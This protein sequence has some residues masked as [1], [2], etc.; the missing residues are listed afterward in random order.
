MPMTTLFFGYF[1][2]PWLFFLQPERFEVIKSMLTKPRLIYQ[3]KPVSPPPPVSFGNSSYKIESKNWMINLFLT[4]LLTQRMIFVQGRELRPALR[5]WW[6][7]K[8]WAWLLLSLPQ[9]IVGLSVGARLPGP[10]FWSGGWQ[11][12]DHAQTKVLGTQG[13]YQFWECLN[14]LNNVCK[15][16]G[17]TERHVNGISDTVNLGLGKISGDMKNFWH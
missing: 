1:H 6:G 2:S 16:R 7:W 12:K 3:L 11:S 4:L 13:N 9:V 5:K 17:L 15:G 14:L 10:L 8:V